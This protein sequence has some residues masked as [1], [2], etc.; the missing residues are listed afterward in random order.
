MKKYIISWGC[1][2]CKGF[3]EVPWKN[4]YLNCL[5]WKSSICNILAYLQT[6]IFLCNIITLI[7]IC[8]IFQCVGVQCWKNITLQNWTR[9]S[10]VMS[11][12]LGIHNT[13]WLPYTSGPHQEGQQCFL[14]IF[15]W[16]YWHVIHDCLSTLW[17]NLKQLADLFTYWTQSIF[18]NLP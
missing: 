14:L 15:L 17:P 18:T 16:Q 4:Y 7:P 2:F 6:L 3:H 9:F 13:T 12:V 11:K 5:T 10:Y 8:W 1:Q